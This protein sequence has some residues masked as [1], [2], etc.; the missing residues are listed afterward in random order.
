MPKGPCMPTYRFTVRTAGAG[1]LYDEF[2]C[3]AAYFQE[4]GAFTVLKDVEHA[5]V[6]AVKTA[7]VV[8]ISRSEKPVELV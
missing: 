4:S 8:R 3:V 5:V 2:E 6:D 7:D 1:G